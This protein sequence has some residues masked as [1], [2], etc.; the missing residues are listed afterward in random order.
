M[1]MSSIYRL[2]TSK[3]YGTNVKKASKVH[4]QRNKTFKHSTAV[5]VVPC[6]ACK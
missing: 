4:I 3:N 1:N 5:I 6:P 2:I